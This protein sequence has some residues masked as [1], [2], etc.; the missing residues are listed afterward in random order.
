MLVKYTLSSLYNELNTH[1]SFSRFRTSRFRKF[2][3]CHNNTSLRTLNGQE[4]QKCSTARTG[5]EM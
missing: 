1:L 5:L 4:H 2:A 3:G